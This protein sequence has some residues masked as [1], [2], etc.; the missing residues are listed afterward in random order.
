[1]S[2]EDAHSMIKKILSDEQ[3]TPNEEVYT[4][5]RM[6]CKPLPK[7]KCFLTKNCEWN[8]ARNRCSVKKDLKNKYKVAKS[9]KISRKNLRGKPQKTEKPWV[10]AF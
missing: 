10:P 7:I 2:D 1:M 5:Y 3:R 6:E 8:Q 4:Q 9:R